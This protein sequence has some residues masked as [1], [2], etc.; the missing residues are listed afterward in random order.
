MEDKSKESILKSY[1]SIKP[2]NTKRAVSLHSSLHSSLQKK[3][4]DFSKINNI[5]KYPQ[6]NTERL[7]EYKKRR[8]INIKV[9]E[10]PLTS[11][12]KSSL[13]LSKKFVVPKNNLIPISYIQDINN[14][15][16]LEF[17]TNYILKY[18]QNEDSF[19]KLKKS[20][21]L[22]RD[23]KKRNFEDIYLKIQKSL[24]T[25]SKFFF[26]DKLF[27][28]ENNNN[29]ISFVKNMICFFYDYNFNL[30]KFCNLLV[31]ELRNEKEQNS[32]LLK[33]MY[34]QNLRLTSKTKEH[35]ELNEYITK[36][37]TKF[38]SNEKKEDKIK[39]IKN[40]SLKKENAQLLSI[41]NLEE[42][43]KDLT[44]LLDKNKEYY[45]KYKESQNLVEEKQRK[46][47]Q[48]RFAYTKELNDKNIQ[49]AIEKDKQNELIFK[50]NDL[51][52]LIKD[53]Q[54]KDEQY[55]RHIIELQAQVKKLQMIIDEKIENI[56]MLNEEFETFYRQYNKEKINH[57][58]TFQ[59]LQTLEN[60]V[61]QEKEEREL[62]EKEEKEK[63]E[64]EKEDKKNEEN[65]EEKKNEENKNENKEEIKENKKE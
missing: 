9:T 43:I 25:Q 16:N 37:E 22:I 18:A 1:L 42:E 61:I 19:F 36:Y 13:D 12:G 39:E 65:K 63:E 58:H 2:I 57:Q 60:K 29:D 52:K 38:S 41:F 59:A 44:E 14:S 11:L 54:K 53:Y 49:F 34:E 48:M 10:Y 32:K 35:N 46:N 47:D 6:L 64:K 50:V 27:E 51:E 31:N 3:K 24:E 8:K 30:N 21:N 45:N 26:E 56:Y 15:N 23:E 28:N 17:R 7:L 20:I 62:K 40:K 55:K 5:K 33:K 4:L